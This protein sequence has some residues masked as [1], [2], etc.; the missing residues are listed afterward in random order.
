MDDFALTPAERALFVALNQRGVRFIIIGM[1]AAVLQGA[2]IATQD[3][4]VWFSQVEDEAI[5]HAATDAGG[6]W[7]SGFGMQPPAFGGDDFSRIDVVLTAHGLETFATEYARSI[8]RDIEGVTFRVLPL[9]RVIVSKRATGRLKDT[10][11]LPVL[12]ATLLARDEVD[13]DS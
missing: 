3:L 10:A 7:I 8:E 4:D 12:E 13:K 11:Q 2:P 1:G 6:F 9:D 5:R